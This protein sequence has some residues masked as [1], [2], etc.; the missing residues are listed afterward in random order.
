MLF[1]LIEKILVGDP[2]YIPCQECSPC[3]ERQ[4]IVNTLVASKTIVC[5]AN[6]RKLSGRCIAGREVMPGGYAGPAD[7]RGWIR[8]VSACASNE[9]SEEER[10]YVD[11]S[12]PRV[13][14]IIAIPV[15]AGPHL[16][17]TENWVIDDRRY[18][19][20]RGRL[21]SSS[22]SALRKK[23]AAFSGGGAGVSGETG[24][25]VQVG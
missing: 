6:S 20:K 24:W 22:L 4:L 3:L 23:P 12:D 19:E 16:H 11:G 17:Q 18:W 7:M 15:L 2:Y 1:P 21:S 5:L 14:D 13:L 10:R 8:P 9:V 25:S